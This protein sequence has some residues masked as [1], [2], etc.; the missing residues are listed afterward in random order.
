[1]QL[2]IA[3]IFGTLSVVLSILWGFMT[4]SRP[5]PRLRPPNVRPH[6]PGEVVT[7]QGDE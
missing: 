7:G 5:A 3:V 2:A 1:M 6:H 4:F